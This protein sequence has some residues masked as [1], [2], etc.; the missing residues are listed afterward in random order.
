M[1]SQ[2]KKCTVMSP[3]LA[4][5][6][7]GLRW[8]KALPQPSKCTPLPPPASSWGPCSQSHFREVLVLTQSGREV[9]LSWRAL[10]RLAEIWMASSKRTHGA[11]S[12]L[13]VAF[14]QEA[15]CEQ[16]PNLPSVALW[17]ALLLWFPDVFPNSC[18]LKW[19]SVHSRHAVDM[20]KLFK[21][22]GK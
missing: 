11:Q 10:G 21:R 13:L 5:N 12:H 18:D 14:A 4:E 15:G 16:S 22:V 20:G 9:L 6:I 19:V 3:I 1:S 7:S 8:V 17:C 2:L